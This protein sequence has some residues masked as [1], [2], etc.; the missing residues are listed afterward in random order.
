MV[1]YHEGI[2]PLMIRSKRLSKINLFQKKDIIMSSINNRTLTPGKSQVIRERINKIVVDKYHK[3]T[4]YE[5]PNRGSKIA[6]LPFLA[7]RYKEPGRNAQQKARAMWDNRAKLIVCEETKVE[8]REL[9]ECQDHTND[10]KVVS[11]RFEPG[12]YDSRGNGGFRNDAFSHVIVPRNASATL[13]D[14]QGQGGGY[15]TLGPGKHS[16][17]EYDLWR[18]ISSLVFDLDEWKETDIRFGLERNRKPVGRPVVETVKGSGAPG[19]SFTKSITLGRVRQKGTNWHASASVTASVTVKQGGG[20]APGGSEQTLSTT[21]EAGGGGDE[22][23]SISREVSI[24]ITGVIGRSGRIEADA[25]G[26]L[27]EVD[28][29]VFQQLLNERTGETAEREGDIPVEKFDVTFSIRHG[30][31]TEAET[32]DARSDVTLPNLEE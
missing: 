11:T 10:G 29:Q 4:V 15:I 6:A 19:D 7:G 22:S 17:R 14:H 25:I 12:E 20:P 3:I 2:E 1:N 16:L 28:Q 31:I 13:F 21:L 18:R 8:P 26:Q 32:D 27:V 24:S 9:L 23:E 30:D 5:G